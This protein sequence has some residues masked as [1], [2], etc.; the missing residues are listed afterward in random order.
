MNRDVTWVDRRAPSDLP[1][2]PPRAE[3]VRVL[4]VAGLGRV[5]GAFTRGDGDDA[6]VVWG[7]PADGQAVEPAP[8]QARGL[9]AVHGLRHPPAL[10]LSA[11]GA[12]S[13]VDQPGH[14][15]LAVTRNRLKVRAKLNGRTWWLRRYRLASVRVVRDDGASVLRP[16]RLAWRWEGG[17]EL[18]LAVAFALVM[19]IDN[20]ITSFGTFG[21]LTN[22]HADERPGRP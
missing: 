15:C 10:V 4:E 20:D 17:D 19:G 14:G 18:D 9:A 21:R 1:G 7:R 6:F 3:L 12:T 5:M 16:R 22:R 2:A 13:R 11:G 8:P